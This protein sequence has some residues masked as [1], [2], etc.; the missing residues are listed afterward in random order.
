MLGA[1]SVHK[2]HSPAQIC[3][4]DILYH[5][6]HG[7]ETAGDISKPDPTI[8]AAC[9]VSKP[10][11]GRCQTHASCKVHKQWD[12]SVLSVCCSQDPGR[13]Q[14]GCTAPVLGTAA[15]CVPASSIPHTGRRTESMH[16]AIPIKPNY[17]AKGPGSAAFIRLPGRGLCKLSPRLTD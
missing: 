7:M 5:S 9:C 6:L 1:G 10:H 16:V 8:P 3:G 14:A 13:S 12:H 2:R 15:A 4:G 17:I 11:L